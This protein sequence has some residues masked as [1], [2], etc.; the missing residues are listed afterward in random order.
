MTELERLLITERIRALKGAYCVLLDTGE[1]DAYADLFVEDLIVDISD[2]IGADQ[3]E[4]LIHGRDIFIQQTRHFVGEGIRSH[5][6]HPGIIEVIS[7]TE[8]TAIWPMH[9][10]I[11]FP[12]GASSPSGV[13]E[14]I[15]YGFYYETYRLEQEK[16]RISRLKLVRQKFPD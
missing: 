14:K 9:D 2:D 16:W 7:A 13:K 8:A 1:W 15:G 5:L 12:E 3:G 4:V 10:K 11:Y 6:V